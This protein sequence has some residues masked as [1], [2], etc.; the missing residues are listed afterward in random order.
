LENTIQYSREKDSWMKVVWCKTGHGK[1]RTKVGG[2]EKMKRVKEG[3]YGCGTFYMYECGIL[4]L[5]EVLLRRGVRE[6]GEIMEGM[7]QIREQ[8]MHIWKCNNKTPFVT[9]LY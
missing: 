8:Y 2:R 7:N 3:E 5:A 9:T 6:E 4:K 1:R